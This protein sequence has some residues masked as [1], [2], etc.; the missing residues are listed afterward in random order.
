MSRDLAEP[1]GT[2]NDEQQPKR[3]K[4]SVAQE[5]ADPEQPS[6]PFDR[7]GMALTDGCQPVRTGGFLTS[8]SIE[9]RGLSTRDQ[10][11]LIAGL[12]VVIVR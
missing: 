8:S 9:G 1:I 12:T 7:A 5:L 10:T 3:R 2:E 4:H 11:W 6:F